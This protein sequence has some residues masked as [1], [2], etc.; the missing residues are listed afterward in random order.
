MMTNLLLMGA[1]LAA[2]APPT[3]DP[4]DPDPGDRV[5]VDSE[6]GEIRFPARVRHPTGTPCIDTFG[7]R[8][9]AFIGC[10]KSGG[11]EVVKPWTPHWVFH[12]SGVIHKEGTGCVA[13]PCPGGLIADNRN[14]IYEPKPTV[15]FDLK[16]APPAGTRVV[17]RIR[18][19]GANVR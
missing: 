1:M 18:R 14:P 9:Q 8:I 4:V 10:E 7:Q 11:K 15:R 16:K 12:G 2:S 5:A 17:V 13:C 19:V 3:A 6:R